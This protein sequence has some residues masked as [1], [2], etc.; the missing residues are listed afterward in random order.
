MQKLEHNDFIFDY[1]GPWGI[2]CIYNKTQVKNCR[3]TENNRIKNSTF[4]AENSTFWINYYYFFLP[5]IET[6]ILCVSGIIKLS[7]LTTF[8]R[9][10]STKFKG[11]K[12][13]H[14]LVDDNV[15]FRFEE[16]R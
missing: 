2:N 16:K 10:C 6:P 13:W 15:Y 5:K 11:S 4:L 8:H 14:E 1:V 9:N 7:L 3:P 12:E